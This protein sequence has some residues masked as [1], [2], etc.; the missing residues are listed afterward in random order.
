[1]PGGPIN[2]WVDNIKLLWDEKTNTYTN[3][4]GVETRVVGWGD[5]TGFEYLD[6]DLKVGDSNYF[7]DL[8]EA[9]V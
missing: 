8:V 4:L 6:I 2:C 9:L 7:H 3:N 5:T 1:L